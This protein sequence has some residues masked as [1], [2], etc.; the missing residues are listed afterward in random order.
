[1]TRVRS[2]AIKSA[3]PTRKWVAA[4]VVALAAIATMYVS[5]GGWNQEES[6]ALIGWFV[7][8]AT[9]YLVPNEDTPGGVPTKPVSADDYI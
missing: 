7:Q 8:A 4:Q 1:M 3:A 6:V 5:T 9:T 2:A